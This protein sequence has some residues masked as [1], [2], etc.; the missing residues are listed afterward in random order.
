MRNDADTSDAVQVPWIVVLEA[1]TVA[2]PVLVEINLP[3]PDVNAEITIGATA[4]TTGASLEFN[5]TSGRWEPAVD[6][7]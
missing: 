6:N 1:A 5:S 3:Y 7:T 4:P 2:G